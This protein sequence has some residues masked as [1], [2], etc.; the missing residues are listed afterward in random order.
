MSH[1]LTFADGEFSTKAPSDPKEIFLS[2]MEQILPLAKHG[3]S[4]RTRLSQGGQWPTAPI[5][6]DHAA[7]S[8]HAALVQ[9]ER[10][11]PW[12]MPCTESPPIAPCLP[13]YHGWRLP[14]RTTIMNFRR[15]LERHQLARQFVS[16]PSSWLAE[17]KGVMMTQGTLVDA[18]I[19]E[20]PN[21]AR[22]KGNNAIRRCIQTRR[23]NQWHF[24]AKATVN[25]YPE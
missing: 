9:P 24:G 4:H 12:K 16:R 10:Q 21:S 18:A 7:Y 25:R 19:I 2:R 23:S 5:A 17:A 6:G 20:A 13:D 11:L 15:L 22:T 8:L 3:G 14:D 1:Q